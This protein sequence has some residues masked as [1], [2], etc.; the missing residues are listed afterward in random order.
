MRIFEPRIRKRFGVAVAE[1]SYKLRMAACDAEP[2]TTRWASA[3]SGEQTRKRPRVHRISRK[4]LYRLIWSEPITAPAHEFNAP[5]TRQ[6][7]E[8]SDTTRRCPHIIASD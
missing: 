4:D 5:T 2:A 1:R 6:V 3:P 7:D 8:D